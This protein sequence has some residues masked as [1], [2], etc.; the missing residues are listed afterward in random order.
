MKQIKI[1]FRKKLHN[2]EK[3]LQYVR[4]RTDY[5]LDEDITF[6][7]VCGRVKN[8]YVYGNDEIKNYQPVEYIKT[9]IYK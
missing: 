1:S 5:H 7:N 3:H 9:E 2:C 6:C 8:H 4:W